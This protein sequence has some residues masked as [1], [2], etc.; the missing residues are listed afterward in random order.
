MFNLFR[1]LADDDATARHAA[2]R[3][4]MRRT[5][6]FKALKV[7]RARKEKAARQFRLMWGAPT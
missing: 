2:A 4:E 3:A 1:A 6:K 5:Q 7:R